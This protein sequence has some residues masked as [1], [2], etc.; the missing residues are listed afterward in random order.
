MVELYISF[1][2]EWFDKNKDKF[3][4]EW[5]EAIGMD[6]GYIIQPNNVE[7]FDLRFNKNTEEI[8]IDVS[9]KDS[10]PNK[11][12]GIFVEVKVPL[13]TDTLIDVLECAVKKF[14]K[15]KALLET[16]K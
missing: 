6:K 12:E 7:V 4:K 8:E 16:I 11:Y 3:E 15:I 9:T 2:K 14:N 1:D 10:D 13:D 5:D